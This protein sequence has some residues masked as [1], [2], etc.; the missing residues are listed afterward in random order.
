MAQITYEDKVKL[1]DNPVAEKNK[2]TAENFNEIKSVVNEN[3][4]LLDTIN[5]KTTINITS[6]NETKLLEKFDGK[7]IFMRKFDIKNMPKAGQAVDINLESF[8]IK[9]AN[10][11]DY[12]VVMIDANGYV[13]DVSPVWFTLAGQLQLRC[14][15]FVDS[16]ISKLRINAGQGQDMSANRGFAVVKY[17]KGA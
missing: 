15:C 7:D 13:Y 3:A 2:G 14:F 12:N 8:G 10:V 4:E 9:T 17:T 16:G 1:K 6:S 11:I 5:E